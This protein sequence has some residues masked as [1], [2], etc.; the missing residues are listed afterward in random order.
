MRS[1]ENFESK[2]EEVKKYL[3][4]FKMLVEKLKD[5]GLDVDGDIL[6]LD[7]AIKT[8]DEDILS[9]ALVGAVS[10]GKTTAI[11]GWLEEVKDNMKIATE[12]SSDEI[13]IYHPNNMYN[14]CQIVDTPGLFGDKE[15]S[16]NNKNNFKFDNIV[17]NNFYSRNVCKSGKQ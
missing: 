9:I 12:E 2:K 11:A 3:K 6:K 14:K 15:K 17:S 16:E 1:I 8:V 7:S 13:L 4:D 5:V 10:D